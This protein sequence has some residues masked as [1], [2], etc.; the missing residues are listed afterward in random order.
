MFAL[1]NRLRG[2]HGYF[3]PILAL[4]T[5]AVIGFLAHSWCAFFVTVT[6][7]WIGNSFGWGDWFGAILEGQGKPNPYREG[8][9]SGVQW[10]AEKLVNSD[11][12]WLLH[13]KVAL[14]IRGA[15]RAAFLLPLACWFGFGALVAF[16]FL[17]PCLLASLYIG[18][19]TTTLWNFKY[20]SD[21]WEHSE[22]WYGIGMWIAICLMVA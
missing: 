4:F 8:K 7:V 14:L 15:Y 1:L 12:N 6:L 13:V 5:G 17:T 3:D 22:V 18:K 10:L 16:V 11:T 2:M 9:S 19:W 20:M 21:A